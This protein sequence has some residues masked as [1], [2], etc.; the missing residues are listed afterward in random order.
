MSD[1]YLAARSDDRCILKVGRSSNPGRRCKDLEAGHCFQMKLVAVWPGAGN[2]ESAVHRALK[3][4]RVSGC[5][6]EWF[7]ASAAEIYAAV[8]LAMGAAERDR[9]RSPERGLDS[10]G[11]S[12]RQAESP[13]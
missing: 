12:E 3:A 5:S 2:H 9:S 10:P 1:L 4:L 6:R 13:L 7:R 8:A 11:G